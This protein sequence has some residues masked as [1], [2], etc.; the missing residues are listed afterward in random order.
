MNGI[1]HRFLEKIM[2]KFKAWLETEEGEEFSFD[3]KVKDV[4]FDAFLTPDE[5][6]KMD[7]GVLIELIRLLW[8][9]GL[10]NNKDWVLNQMLQ[11][12]LPKIKEA[13]RNLIYENKRLAKRFDQ[14]AEIKMMGAATISEILAHHDPTQYPIYNRRAKSSLIKLGVDKNS[15]PK[16]AQIKGSQYEAY[17]KV[18]K[19]VFEKV[20]QVYP[21]ITDLLKL[22]FL[23]Y[24][25]SILAEEKAEKGL[26]IEEKF[27]H[28][29]TILQ[30]LQLGDSLGFD[31]QR[32]VSVASGCRVDAVWKSRVANLGIITYAFE[33]HKSGSRD[34]AILN[35]QRIFNADPTVQ[36][37]VIVSIDKELEKFRREIAT[38]KEDFRNSVGYLR[39]KDLADALIHQEALKKILEGIGLMKKKTPA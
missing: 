20:S 13:F 26:Q 32:E 34:S 38:L 24:Y 19:S 15:L 18:V 39:V 31:I 33:V 21:D 23:L 12:G 5:I 14:M 3:R 25:V 28:D 37:V 36:K 35:L 29:T 7:E 4:F 27:E 30:V 17:V 2:P 16:S 1:N 9:Y 8:S 6:E 22:D 11:S 10:W